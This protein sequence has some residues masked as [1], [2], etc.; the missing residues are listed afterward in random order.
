MVVL[1]EPASGAGVLLGGGGGAVADAARFS[2]T[3]MRALING[4]KRLNLCSLKS[5][6]ETRFLTDNLL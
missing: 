6:L 1:V 4:L 3:K 5:L 2:A